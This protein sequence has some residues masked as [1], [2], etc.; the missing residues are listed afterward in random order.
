MDLGCCCFVMR[1]ACGYREQHES[2]L[3]A[4]LGQATITN[5]GHQIGD[6]FGSCRPWCE[7][8]S[9]IHDL[10]IALPAP[11]IVPAPNT[12]SWTLRLSPSA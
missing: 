6:L 8:I 9:H 4:L 7:S 3:P 2:L 10:D 5:P 12:L 11:S 1:Q